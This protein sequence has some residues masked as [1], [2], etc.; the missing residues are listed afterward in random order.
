MMMEQAREVINSRSNKKI[1][2]LKS[3]S[4]ARN[5]QK[6]SRFIIEGIRITEEIF[7]RRCCVRQLIIS[8]RAAQNERAAMLVDAAMEQGVEV[9]WVADRV[10]D[11]LSETKTSQGVMALIEPETF[12]EKDLDK[13][14][15]PMVVVAHLL[16]DP[17]NLGT[18]IRVADAAGAG[19]LVTTPGTVDFYNPK[20]LRAT[21]GSIFRLP[22][23]RTPSLEDFV[24]KM[25]SSG[26]QVIAAMVSA[27]KRYFDV[28]LTKPT[29]LLLGQEGAGLPPEAALLTDQKVS[30]PM[31]TMIDSLNV[32][33]A[34]SVILYEAVRQKIASGG[35]F[36]K[37]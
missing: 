14:L 5:R 24:I 21:M 12:S 19:G 36:T 1:K 26:Y 31:S 33:S 10:V 2:Y 22:T 25:K 17:G 20:A 4:L 13:G 8:P 16:Q 35:D 9:L 27:R 3:L 23:L 37:K 6:E 28:D 30:I 7:E 11:Y 34:A 15:I 32:A 18:I 29:V